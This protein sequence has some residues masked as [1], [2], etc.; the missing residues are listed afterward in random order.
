MTL[1]PKNY[2][3]YRP[4]SDLQHRLEG[5]QEVIIFLRESS[6]PEDI[7]KELLNH[8]REESHSSLRHGEVHDQ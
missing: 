7:K 2:K 6:L 3:P 5:L 4:L 8:R 1:I